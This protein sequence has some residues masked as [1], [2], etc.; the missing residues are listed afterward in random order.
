MSKSE[1]VTATLGSEDYY[2]RVDVDQFDFHVDEP[3]TLGGGDK[4]PGPFGYVLGSLAA[5]TAI[6]IKMYAQRKS[7]DLGLIKVSAD[8]AYISDENGG[9]EQIIEKIIHIENASQLDDSQKKRLLVISQKCP[10]S[11][12]LHGGIGMKERII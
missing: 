1:S 2:T 12:M 8:F 9:N 11:K 3:L 10:V 4:A 5:C 6:T 7:W